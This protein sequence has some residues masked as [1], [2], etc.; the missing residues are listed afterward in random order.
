MQAS[1]E[2]S[3]FR[4]LYG[5]SPPQ[6]DKEQAPCRLPEAYVRLRGF[7]C[8]GMEQFP[9]QPSSAHIATRKYL[10]FEGSITK[11]QRKVTSHPFGDANV[12]HT[13]EIDPLCTPYS[14]SRGTTTTEFGLKTDAGYWCQNEFS[15]HMG[16]EGPVILSGFSLCTILFAPSNLYVHVSWLLPLPGVDR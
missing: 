12:P 14:C 7:R 1:V 2:V 16:P 9:E 5:F 13:Q 4:L 3:C 15:M 6:F 8:T 11:P 10:N